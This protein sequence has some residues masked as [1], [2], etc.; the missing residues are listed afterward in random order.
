MALHRQHLCLDIV[1]FPEERD[2]IVVGLEQTDLSAN[3]IH[4]DN[5]TGVSFLLADLTEIM[6]NY[7]P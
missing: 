7:I 4:A 2:G 3:A 5:E 1:T 6:A